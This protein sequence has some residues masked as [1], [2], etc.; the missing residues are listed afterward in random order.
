MASV[1]YAPRAPADLERLCDF[2]AR[3]DPLAASQTID[4][5]L[6]AVTILKRHPLMAGLP[7]PI[8]ASS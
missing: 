1:S 6:D 8:S 7:R 3:T 2:L 4:L 5:I